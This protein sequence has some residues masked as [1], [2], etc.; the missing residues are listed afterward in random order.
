V[1]NYSVEQ[2]IYRYLSCHCSIAFAL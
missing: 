2:L 1:L